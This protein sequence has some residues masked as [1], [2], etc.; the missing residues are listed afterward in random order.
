MWNF[1]KFKGYVMSGYPEL[2]W[3][4]AMECVTKIVV[5][6]VISA[7]IFNYLKSKGIL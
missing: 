3:P 5:V 1:E 6:L 2:F 4:W 7:L